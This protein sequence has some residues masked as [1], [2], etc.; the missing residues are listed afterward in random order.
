MEPFLSDEPAL[1]FVY[2]TLRRGG[3]NDIAKLVPSARFEGEAR[4]RG[5]LYTLGAYP[6][7]VLEPR[8]GWVAGEIYRI[9]PDGWPALDALEQVVTDARPDGEYFRGRSDAEAGDGTTRYCQVYVANPAVMRLDHVIENG[10]WIA[11]AYAR[12]P[13]G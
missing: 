5:I 6:A 10:D 1:L 11:F 7:L 3:S 4:L 12:K 9:A 2:G 8:A 13:R